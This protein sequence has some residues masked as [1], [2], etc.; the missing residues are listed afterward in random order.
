MAGNTTHYGES[1]RVFM[2][3]GWRERGPV[4]RLLSVAVSLSRATL[5]L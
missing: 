1:E 5:Y 4:I 2:V 3:F